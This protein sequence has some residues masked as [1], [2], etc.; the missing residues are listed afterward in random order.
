VTVAWNNVSHKSFNAE[1]VDYSGKVV[2]FYNALSGNTFLVD[3]GNL[4]KG[5]Y[6]LKMQS[7]NDF[8]YGK[9]IFN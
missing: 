2:K 5:I 1:V 6:F 7:G 8:R 3:R 9:I 4:A